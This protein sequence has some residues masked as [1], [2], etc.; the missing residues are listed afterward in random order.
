[1]IKLQIHTKDNFKLALFNH[2]FCILL[3]DTKKPNG[4]AN[5]FYCIL[6]HLSI[7]KSAIYFKT[8]RTASFFL[9]QIYM[10]QENINIH[11]Y[12]AFLLKTSSLYPEESA[13]YH[14][15]NYRDSAI[16]PNWPQY[17]VALTAQNRN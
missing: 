7:S 14:S 5:R 3:L 10:S 2:N 15:G 9:L 4:M 13:L 16:S 17:N 6:I 11:K 8:T 1:M 12:L